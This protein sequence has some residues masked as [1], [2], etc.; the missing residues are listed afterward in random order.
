MHEPARLVVLVLGV[1]AL[2]QL[3]AD[4]LG[5]QRLWL[6][7]QVV[8]DDGVGGIEDRLRG[9]VV[10]LEHD[11]GGVGEGV[12]ELEDVAHVGGAEPV[13]GLVAVAH[14]AQVAVALGQQEHE[15]VLGPVGVLVLVDQ[16]V[17]EAL[18]VVGQHLG[19]AT[20]EL[21][22]DHEKVVEVH[23]AG[24]QQPV[25]VLGVDI[26]DLAVEQAPGLVAEGVHADQL[27]LGLADQA[28]DRARGE[29]LGVEAQVPDHVAREPHSVGLVVDGERRAVAETAGVPPQDAHAGGVER[30]HPHALGH[31]PDQ[32]GD[33]LAHLVGRLVGEGDGHQLER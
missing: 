8:G 20:E 22:R 23:G 21:H 15:L 2:D 5:P 33:P 26:C 28:V 16:H 11:H 6:A 1:V 17:A 4:L 29:A 14:H 27:V 25:L 3:A 24:G 13:D 10:L 31:R 18:L 7:Q 9:T 32:D 30:R 19:L 12:L